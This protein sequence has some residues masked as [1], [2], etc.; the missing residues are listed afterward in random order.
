M[1]SFRIAIV[2]KS[3]TCVCK[4]ILFRLR[5]TYYACK[6]DQI[7]ITGLL[8]DSVRGELGYDQQNVH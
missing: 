5:Y 1:T 7:S 3:K 6:I 8:C 2:L 4:N